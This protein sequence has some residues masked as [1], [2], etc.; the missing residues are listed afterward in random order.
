MSRSIGPAPTAPP[1]WAG[2]SGQGPPALSFVRALAAPLR[3]VRVVVLRRRSS[4]H[5]VLRC[6]DIWS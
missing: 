6:A 2:L 4:L 5:G 1:E 3:L